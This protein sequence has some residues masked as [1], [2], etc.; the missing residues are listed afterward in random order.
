MCA[1]RSIQEYSKLVCNLFFDDDTTDIH[2]MNNDKSQYMYS[3]EK[4]KLAALDVFLLKQIQY[5][6][7][8]TGYKLTNYESLRVVLATVEIAK[9]ETV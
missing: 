6:R 5:G 9:D 1:R 4:Q 8:E 3:D 2:I 7:I